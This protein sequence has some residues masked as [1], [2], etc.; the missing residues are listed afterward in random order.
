MVRWGNSLS[1]TF[2]CPSGI[3]RQLSLLLFNVYTDNL[4]HHPQPTG[5]EYYV[6]G[7]WVNSLSCADDMVL[8]APKVTAL[9]TLLEL[10]RAYAG[11]HDIVY[12]TTKTLCLLV[13][14]TQSRG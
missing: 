9:Q 11:P 8:L 13:R 10:C 5:V 6:G 3:R 12:N 2:R 7:A 14:P 1:M 4:N